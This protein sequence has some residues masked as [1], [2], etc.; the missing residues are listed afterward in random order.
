MMNYLLSFVVFR[1]YVCYNNSRINVLLQGV[2]KDFLW[3]KKVSSHVF[4]VFL[5]EVMICLAVFG[6]IFF[7]N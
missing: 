4:T 7:V 3:V 5:Y 2:V 6:I 1:I